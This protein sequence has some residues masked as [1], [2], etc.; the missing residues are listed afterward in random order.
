[1]NQNEIDGE[2][3]SKNQSIGMTPVSKNQSP[4]EYFSGGL[5]VSNGKGM[6]TNNI[7]ADTLATTS[8]QAELL[9]ERMQPIVM[10]SK[11]IQQTN[12]V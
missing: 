6:N 11:K 2:F 4:P 10:T 3:G 8:S 7:V 5:I 12:K 1:M 9:T